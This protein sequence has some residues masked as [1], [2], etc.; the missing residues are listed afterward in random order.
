MGATAAVIM[1]VGT[2]FSAASS[3]R[4]GN[5]QKNIADY[6]ASIADMNAGVN[7]TRA[8][9][10]IDRGG[11][12]ETIKRR[13]T[14]ALIGSQRA[15]LAAQGID[16]NS[17]SAVDVQADSAYYGELDALTIRT[18]AAR[19][20]WGYKVEAANDRATAQ[21][22]RYQGK[23]A[24][25]AGRNAAIGTILSTGG[26]MLSEK[27]GFSNGTKKPKTKSG[28]SGSVSPAPYMYSQV[29]KS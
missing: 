22:E 26:S 7:D 9:D 2:G 28:S 4:A 13:T 1:G 12:A 19:E 21:D 5:A 25:Q 23:L 6:N 10:A 11:I 17:G 29:P 8:Q 15:G 20:A 18:D 16:V 27:Y 24:Q 14:R 3:W